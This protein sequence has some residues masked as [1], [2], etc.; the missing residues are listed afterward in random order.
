MSHFTGDNDYRGSLELINGKRENKI[1]IIK[2]IF[3]FYNGKE[4]T[5]SIQITT[6][7]HSMC[8]YDLNH[9]FSNV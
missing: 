9:T 7:Q 8:P 1:E 3:F 5:R 6:C 4:N 2:T